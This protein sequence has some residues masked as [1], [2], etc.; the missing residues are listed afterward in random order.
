MPCT[1]WLCL[2]SLGNSSFFVGWGAHLYLIVGF[3]L[4]NPGYRL[5]HGCCICPWQVPG[6]LISVYDVY[7]GQRAPLTWDHAF[8]CL[9]SPLILCHVGRA[10]VSS[11]TIAWLILPAFPPVLLSYALTVKP[12]KI[13]WEQLHT[14]SCFCVS[15]HSVCPFWNH[16]PSLIFH[17]SNFSSI[18]KIQFECHLCFPILL[19]P[20][21]VTLPLCSCRPALSVIYPFTYLFMCLQG[22]RK[23]R[24]RSFAI[25]SGFKTWL[26]HL[27]TICLCKRDLTFENLFLPSL[28]NGHE[29]LFWTVWLRM[30]WNSLWGA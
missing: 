23:E 11:M 9:A 13:V 6:E 29:E 30:K 21:S 27:L 4:W 12:P 25:C 3:L 18:F 22:H 17:V 14:F 28:V 5:P 20:A 16:L 7:S 10:W 8:R 15:F 19:P 2:F 1:F 26:C 24:N